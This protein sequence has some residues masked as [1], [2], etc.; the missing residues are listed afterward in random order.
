MG[1]YKISTGITVQCVQRIA[2]T[3]CTSI[4]SRDG[5]VEQQ[6]SEDAVREKWGVP[7]SDVPRGLSGDMR[8]K[9]MLQEAARR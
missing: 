6:E 3:L 8:Y 2:L 4:T 1:I 9:S 5:S 7:L